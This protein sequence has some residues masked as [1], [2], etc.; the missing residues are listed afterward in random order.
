MRQNDKRT[1]RINRPKP[2]AQLHGPGRLPAGASVRSLRV[3]REDGRA[4]GLKMFLDR[5][6]QNK[7]VPGYLSSVPGAEFFAR[8][9]LFGWPRPGDLGQFDIKQQAHSCWGN[10]RPAVVGG[11]AGLRLTRKFRRSI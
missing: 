10:E 11:K 6:R 9:A 3:D 4:V 2:R 1:T 5:F 7:V 8:P